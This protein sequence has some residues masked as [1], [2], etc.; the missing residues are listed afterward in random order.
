MEDT[1]IKMTVTNLRKEDLRTES[2]L[3][4]GL[5]K[6]R[7]IR[8]YP[9]CVVDSEQTEPFTYEPAVGFSFGLATTCIGVVFECPDDK[10]PFYLATHVRSD[11]EQK[12]ITG[13]MDKTFKRLKGRETKA[14]L[15][16]GWDGWSEEALEDI[17]KSLEEERIN[18]VYAD[19]LGREDR[20]RYP[21][22][23]FGRG[24]YESLE[25]MALCTPQ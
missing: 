1:I 5:P 3:E 14:Y 12:E 4:E 2:K 24:V 21:Y 9:G 11:S 23:V 15:V 8:I 13:L 19:V 18:I 17:L 16:G 7:Y 6:G 20:R 22:F 10:K 25:K